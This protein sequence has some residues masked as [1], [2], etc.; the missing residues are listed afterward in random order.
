MAQVWVDQFHCTNSS[1]VPVE[2]LQ[3]QRLHSG[4]NANSAAI[5]VVLARF[6]SLVV[7]HTP[8]KGE[9]RGSIPR[10]TVSFLPNHDHQGLTPCRSA[11]SARPRRC[12]IPSNGNC[13]LSIANN[14]LLSKNGMVILMCVDASLG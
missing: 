1:A 2:V 9:V 13:L 6:C 10:R 8:V 7:E 5:H 3:T 14:A 12:S 11:A 4:I